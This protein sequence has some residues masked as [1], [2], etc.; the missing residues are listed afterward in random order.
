MF[1]SVDSGEYYLILAALGNLKSQNQ[2][3]KIAVKNYKL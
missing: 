1:L 3:E 2:A